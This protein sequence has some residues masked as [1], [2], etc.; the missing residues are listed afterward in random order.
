MA[1][2]TFTAEVIEK[3]VTER[4]F[5]LDR[6]GEP[7]PGVLWTPE[8]AT[9]PRPLV[10][11][12]HGGTQ[13]KR[14]PNILALARRLVR[15]HGFAAVAI[16]LPFHGERIPEDE[17]GM[18]REERRQRLGGRLFGRGRGATTAQALGD[19]TA[20]LDAV[21]ALDEVGPGGPVGYW[22]LSMG[23]AFGV[24]LV[25]SEP[26]IGAAVLGLAGW[27]EGGRLAGFDELAR[28]VTVPVLFIVQWDDE[29]VD[30]DHAC[31]LFGLLGSSRK[32]LHANPGRHVEVP[33]FE[34][35]AAE[36]FFAEHLAADTPAEAPAA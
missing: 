32:T 9:G 10:L 21:T 17:R 36:A 13:H 18:S 11:F 35:D 14:V 27:A 5:T 23:C 8:G 26:R 30:H 3:G 15:H 29:V 12:G 4:A 1:G 6:P 34:R 28:Q 24:P 2:P 20:A 19:W 31:A 16:D 33:L 22:G 25:A 7:V